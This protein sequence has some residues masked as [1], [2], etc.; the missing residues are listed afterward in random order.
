MS[1]KTLENMNL[2]IVEI[3]SLLGNN[4]NFKGVKA[5]SHSYETLL[6]QITVNHEDFKSYSMLDRLVQQRDKMN[7]ILSTLEYESIPHLL[8][9]GLYLDVNHL[10][11]TVERVNAIIPQISSLVTN[12]YEEYNDRV[13]IVSSTRKGEEYLYKYMIKANNEEIIK[14]STRPNQYHNVLTDN[15]N[16]TLLTNITNHRGRRYD[17]VYIDSEL[18]AKSIELA[19]MY[20]KH[21]TNTFMF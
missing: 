2:I 16:Y 3:E 7:E 17:M 6:K 14:G 12:W 15:Y 9:N 1:K 11:T 18:D 20:I 10:T 19:K 13:L 21:E 4:G 5:L 8:S